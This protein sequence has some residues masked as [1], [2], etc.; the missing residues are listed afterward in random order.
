MYTRA[1]F[2]SKAIECSFRLC[3]VK[4]VVLKNHPLHTFE[5]DKVAFF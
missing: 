2:F 4:S 3:M 1:P 5:Y